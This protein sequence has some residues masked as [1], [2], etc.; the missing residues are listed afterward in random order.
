MSMME[1]CGVYTHECEGDADMI[2]VGPL[3]GSIG[4]DICTWFEGSV[5]T[6]KACQDTNCAASLM[7]HS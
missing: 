2:R 5:F 1:Y 3:A 6:S 7:R 4:K